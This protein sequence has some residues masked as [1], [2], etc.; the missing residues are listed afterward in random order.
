MRLDQ[1]QRLLQSVEPA[2]HLVEPRV[3]RRV[4]RLDRNLQGLRF[5]V[6]HGNCYTIDRDRLLAFAELDELGVAPG[7]DLPRR[8][9]LL[10]QP[11]DGELDD[12]AQP[13][14]LINR[15]RRLLYH[16]CIHLVLE[17]EPPQ[18]EASQPL[19]KTRRQQIGEVE[20]AE[21]RDVLTRE[22]QLFLPAGDWEVYV[23]F[24][25]TALEL[26]AFAPRELGNYFP[27]VADWQAILAVL[28]QD[29]DHREL[30]V[31]LQRVD[32]AVGSTGPSTGAIDPPAESPAVTGSPR[33]G[34]ATFR[35]WQAK[36]AQTAEAGN[37]VKAALTYQQ[38]AHRA[39]RNHRAEAEAAARAEIK[40]LAQR[41]QAVLELTP[42]EAQQWRDALLP[43]LEPAATAGSW[44]NE[45]RILHELQKICIEQEHGID[46][47]DLIGWIRSFG[48]RPI[49]RPLPLMRDVL[50]LRHL[51]AARRRVADARVT[52][53]QQTRLVG[54]LD[55]VL[56]RVETRSRNQLRQIINGVFDDVGFVPQHVLEV[57]AR[58]KLVEELLD[59]I[60]ERGYLTMANLRDAISKNDLKLADVASLREVPFGGCLLRAD[61]Q[62]DASLDGVYR[63][64]AVYLRWPQI[65]SS[66]AF[67]TQT[68]RFFTKHLVVPFGGAY[69]VLEFVH[70]LKTKITGKPVHAHDLPLAEM[71]SGI[72]ETSVATPVADS[73]PASSIIDILTMESE[74]IFW[75]GVLV[76]GIWISLLIHRPGFR[77]WNLALL[78]RGW[79]TVRNVVVEWPAR[80]LNSQT[81]QQILASRAFAVLRGYV[82]APGLLVG[83]VVSALWLAGYSL[84]R[85]DIVISYLAITLFLNST[86]GRFVSEWTID[87]L[88]R[89][90]HEVKMQILFA[91]VQWITDVFG[92]M[93]AVVDRMV[94]AVDD[95]LRFRAGDNRFLHALKLAGGVAWFFI[96]YV[97]VFVFTLLVEPQINP[98]KHFPVVTVSH[99]IILPTGP[100]LASKLTPYLGVVQAQTLVWTTIFLIPGVFGFLVWE[101]KE[102]WRLYA[103]NRRQLLGAEPIGHHGETMLRLLRPGV[104]SG[105]LPKAYATLRRGIRKGGV[106]ET[107]RVQNK[108]AVVE[109]AEDAIRYFVE[110]ELVALLQEVA[111][112]P[113]ITLVVG[114][115][116]AA[117][118]RIDV[119]LLRSD[120]P[121]QVAMLRWQYVDEQL[122]GLVEPL[123]WMQRIAGNDRRVLVAA[124]ER[125][126]QRSGVNR[127]GGAME[128]PATPNATWDDSVTFWSSV[129]QSSPSPA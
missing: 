90:W 70:Y 20:F 68:G 39:P 3:L 129:A 37:G 14:E 92:R 69:L 118:N 91:I 99:K 26:N 4:I 60:V 49:R 85:R 97:V 59:H 40:L 96:S 109:H 22:D 13:S 110:R 41:L 1:L 126:F 54:L 43:L 50:T 80:L 127:V 27:A 18:G 78:S 57:V 42:D 121:E 32:A 79:R 24:A 76:L 12:A 19:A 46:Q 75:V 95:W 72:A 108:R 67:G 9:I 38:A 2:A 107:N 117:T 104:H 100:G 74:P 105:T 8:V 15:Y 89:F 63:R 53:T 5:L 106:W 52:S 34:L 82:I 93:S 44:S 86:I 31:R 128:L 17:G 61:R 116:R 23:E 47:L 73:S 124:L 101:L 71:A 103:A 21:I 65:L 10:P 33:F 120:Q 36:A 25:A 98:L 56:P 125:L 113:E 112:R 58:R 122:T 123:G 88:M 77:A 29:L 6:P 87:I 48:R 45:A 16:A 94:Y 83:M 114:S 28:D 51:R 7:S 115:I 111:F 81:I 35:Q 30:L 62:F 64:G 84:D 55:G 119:E 66:L 11:A 102:N